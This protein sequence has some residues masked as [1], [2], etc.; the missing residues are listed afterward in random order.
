M[1]FGAMARQPLKIP[2]GMLIFQD[3]AWRG[4]WITNWYERVGEP[5]GSKLLAELA[6][7]A[8]AGVIATPVEAIYPLEQI[9]DAIAHAQRPQRGGKILLRCSPS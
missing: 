7:L 8:A 2:N 9:T 1:T 6:A 5:A 3:I 4:F